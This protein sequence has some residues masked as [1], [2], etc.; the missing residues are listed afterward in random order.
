MS[1][2]ALAYTRCVICEC[3]WNALS[4]KSLH[5]TETELLYSKQC[6]HRLRHRRSHNN[7]AHHHF[8]WRL[9]FKFDPEFSWTIMTIATAEAWK[10]K[11]RKPFNLYSIGNKKNLCVRFCMNRIR[12]R[13][14]W[15]SVCLLM[16]RL[17]DLFFFFCESWSRVIELWR[18]VYFSIIY[19]FEYHT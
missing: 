4:K 16:R 1:S 17:V 18:S 15:I 8:A 2:C 9:F 3:V 7:C 13:S 12:T 11:Q 10:P 5:K 19:T 14:E 6:L